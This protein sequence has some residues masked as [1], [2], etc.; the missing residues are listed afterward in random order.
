VP[1]GASYGGKV[2]NV[3]TFKIF[4]ILALSA[5]LFIGGCKSA[6]DLTATQAQALIQA[7]YDAL[8]PAP[9]SIVVGDQGMGQGGVA[10]YWSIT[11]K[12]PN[13]LWADFALTP[14]GKKVVQLANGSDKIE[15]RPAIAKDPNYFQ[16]VQSVATGH[17]KVRDVK[18]P[19]DE[20]GGTK[21]AIF[22]EAV[23]VSILPSAL[24]DIAH[25]PGNKLSTKRTATFAVDEGAWKLQSIN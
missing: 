11:K 7:H 10:K 4:G 12:Y 21:S 20:V 2:K 9:I 16:T 15:W 3:S 22:S 25:N 17:L 19:Q 14:D 23:D 5:G 18:D 6:P 13:P 1:N 8:P 24:Q